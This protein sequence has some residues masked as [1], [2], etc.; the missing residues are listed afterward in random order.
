[1]NWWFEMGKFV[2]ELIVCCAIC[3]WVCYTLDKRRRKD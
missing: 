3:N 1:M 2:V